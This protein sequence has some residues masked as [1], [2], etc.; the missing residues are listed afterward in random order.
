MT[1]TKKCKL[2]SEKQE[3]LCLQTKAGQKDKKSK[4]LLP[5]GR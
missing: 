2:V 3:A 5:S 1:R 4:E